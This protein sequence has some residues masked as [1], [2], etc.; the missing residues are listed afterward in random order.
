MSV[1]QARY[2]N[3]TNGRW[4]TYWTV[5]VQ[6]RHSDGRVERIR[7]VSP[8]QTKRGAEQYERELRQSLLEGNHGQDKRVEVKVPTCAEF[9]KEFLRTYAKA[10]NKPS[11]YESK[12]ATFKNHLNPAFGKMTID[13]IGAKEIEQFKARKLEEGY[14][15]KS[16]NNW[17][18]ALRRMLS[19][20][21]EWELISGVPHVKWLKF[22]EPEIDF[23]NFEEADRLVRGAEPGWSAMIL[24]GLL[25]GL[26]HGEL[27]GLRWEDVDLVAGRLMV[28]QSIV[29]KVVGTPKNGRKRE[30]PMSPELCDALKRHRHLRGEYVFCQ[31][32]GEA[33]YQDITK[34]PLWRACRRAGLRRIG[35]HCLRHTFASHLVMRGV[36]LKAVQEMMGHATIE[37]TM[38]YSHLSPDVKRDAVK[39]LDSNYRR[40]PFTLGRGRDDDKGGEGNQSTG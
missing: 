24:T 38:R 22:P 6:F 12:V 31:D 2:R 23:L 28:R 4:R 36:P 13:R 9:A 40:S 25:T 15:P 16:V 14:S 26:R 33:L 27:I 37:M 32:N 7:K 29:R 21:H 17:L 1:R 30:V 3:P 34:W 11:E 19:L 39:L 20:A 5:D 18:T 8:V 10:N 35:W